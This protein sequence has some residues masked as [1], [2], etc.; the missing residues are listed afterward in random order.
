VP[1]QLLS[2]PYL[3]KSARW[4]LSKSFAVFERWA[5][6][7]LDAVIAATPYIRDKFIVMG[8]R[9][10]YKTTIHCWVSFLR[11][12]SI[13]RKKKHMLLTLVVLG[14][15]VVFLRLLRL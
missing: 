4:L 7:K 14:R 2:K 5:C 12:K 9:S 8:V 11:G 10:V 1:K 6:R 15:Y 3:N 13:G